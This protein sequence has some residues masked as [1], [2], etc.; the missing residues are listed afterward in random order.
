MLLFS[1]FV[2]QHRFRGQHLGSGGQLNRAR[3][4]HSLSASTYYSLNHS[5]Q[6]IWLMISNRFHIYMGGGGWG[7][8]G[9]ESVCVCVR[10]RETGRQTEYFTL[11][12][13][14]SHSLAPATWLTLSSVWRWGCSPHVESEQAPLNTNPQSDSAAMF[15]LMWCIW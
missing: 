6:S 5:V 13:R 2:C 1:L 7:G 11:W 14:G 3:S 9:G 10:E 12:R 4:S 8:G 15:F